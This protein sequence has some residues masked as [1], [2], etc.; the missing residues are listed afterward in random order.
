MRLLALFGMVG[1]TACYAQ[2]DFTTSPSSESCYV[3]SEFETFIDVIV[4]GIAN[5]AG[6]IEISLAGSARQWNGSMPPLQTVRLPARPGELKWT[7]P[8]VAEGVYA[9]RVYHDQNNDRKLNVNWRGQPVE[10]YGRSGSCTL[11]KNSENFH[12][13]Q[14]FHRQSPQLV[15]IGLVTPENPGWF[16]VF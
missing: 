2:V 15:E 1:I 13:C 16:S 4:Y 7:F 6:V 8:H 10:P 9:V 12:S 11:L 14:F 5:S 3:G